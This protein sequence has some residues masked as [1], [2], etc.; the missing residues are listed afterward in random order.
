MER[1]IENVILFEALLS[2]LTA[3]LICVLLIPMLI[4]FAKR[5]NLGDVP[6]GRKIHKAKTPSLGGVAITLGAITSFCFWNP[7]YLSESGIYILS[8]V[9]IIFFVGLRDDLKPVNPFVKIVGIVTASLFALYVPDKLFISF[10]EFG[11]ESFTFPLWLAYIISVFFILSLSNAYNLADG[12]DGLAT[13]LA[14]IPASFL[15]VYFYFEGKIYAFGAG[16]ALIG[17]LLGFFRFNKYPASIFMGDGGSLTVGLILSLL[18]LNFL[19][20]S[21]AAVEH[22]LTVHNKLI[23]FIALFLYPISDTVRLILL[24]LGEGSSPMKADKRHGHHLLLRIGCSQSLIVLI[25]S[26]YTIFAILLV[27]FLDGLLNAWS[28]LGLLFCYVLSSF[29]LLMY[30]VNRF[31]GPSK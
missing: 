30:F 15:V 11:S 31:V 29:V 27:F 24:R 2:L 22:S 17:A 21:T 1:G 20:V 28:L 19:N 3:F 8:S 10:Y 18:F 12:L 9:V 25:I 7:S 13:W 23:M 16:V 4:Y 14:I 5:F 26:L 6:G